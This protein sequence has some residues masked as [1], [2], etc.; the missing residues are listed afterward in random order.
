MDDDYFERKAKKK[1][2]TKEAKSVM[3]FMSKGKKKGSLFKLRNIIKKNVI[4]NL[5]EMAM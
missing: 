1:K 4:S 3:G 5:K 2:A